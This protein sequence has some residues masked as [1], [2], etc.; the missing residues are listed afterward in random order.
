MRATAKPN[1]RSNSSRK[2]SDRTKRKIV[3][4][5]ECS[6]PENDSN[7][8]EASTTGSSYATQSTIELH[9][10]AN[11]NDNATTM[12]TSRPN[13]QDASDAVVPRSA[14]WDYAVKLLNGQA[15]CL[16]C[17]RQVSYKGH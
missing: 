17:H 12:D 4:F 3:H 5:D 6:D 13:D 10:P 8:A 16:R 7:V 11:R 15:K 1:G 9:V 2:P 14:V